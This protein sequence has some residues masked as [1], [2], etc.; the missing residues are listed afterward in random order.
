MKTHQNANQLMGSRKASARLL[1]QY[2][3]GHITDTGLIL[4]VLNLTDQPT[5]VKTLAILPRHI[6]DELQQF[7]GYYTP[8]TQIF[9]G[10]YPNVQTVEL[11]KNWFSSR[12]RF[13]SKN[14]R[15]PL[16]RQKT[17]VSRITLSDIQAV[18][19]LADKLGAEKVRQLAEVLRR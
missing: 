14:A 13:K 8:S 18:K 4:G 19:E 9:N 2:Q 15:K 17:Q 7:V 3:K 16:S 1:D 11:V 10:P 6:L 12:K 5:I